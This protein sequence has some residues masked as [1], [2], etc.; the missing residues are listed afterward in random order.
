RE[1][2]KDRGIVLETVVPPVPQLARDWLTSQ[3]LDA[4]VLPSPVL[5]D[6]VA[7]GTPLG[8]SMNL[9]T[10]DPINVI[11]RRSVAD[12]RGLNENQPL[13]DRLL[14]LKGLKLGVA[15]HPP[16]RLRALFESQGL[17]VDDV[18]ETVHVGGK[19]QNRAFA[20]GEVDVLFAHTP[21]LERALLEQEAVLL[22]RL[23]RG[24]VPELSSRVIHTFTFLPEMQ[25]ERPAVAKAIADEVTQWLG[26]LRT[27]PS[28]AVDVLARAFPARERKELELIVELYHRAVPETPALN[29]QG[30]ERSLSFYPEGYARPNVS[31]DALD[32]IAALR[33]D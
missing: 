33:V 30:L 11:V 25:R 18:V 23:S 4:A 9:L 28:S 1:T 10:H 2:L 14:G 16:P 5:L 19:K 13:R 7:R 24:D 3:E 31:V 12:K 32:R 22:V 20:K 29:R 27:N 17:N 6:H 15:R 26:K 21:Y 8:A